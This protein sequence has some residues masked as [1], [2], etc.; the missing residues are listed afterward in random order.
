MGLTRVQ[1]RCKI[2]MHPLVH[3]AG[4]GYGTTFRSSMNCQLLVEEGQITGQWRNPCMLIQASPGCMRQIPVP[5]LPAS[6]VSGSW[7]EEQERNTD[8]YKASATTASANRTDRR[9][10][11]RSFHG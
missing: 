6:V 5:V 3:R 1:E 2:P 7:Q 9:H 4:Q 11:K 8:L 10:I